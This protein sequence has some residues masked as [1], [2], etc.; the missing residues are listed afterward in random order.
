MVSYGCIRRRLGRP[1]LPSVSG[2]SLLYCCLSIGVLYKQLNEKP[3]GYTRLATLWNNRSQNTSRT[4]IHYGDEILQD[5]TDT[6]KGTF[7][8]LNVI[9]SVVILT[10]VGTTRIFLG[11]L[12][13]IE[14]AKLIDR[15]LRFLLLKVVFLGAVVNPEPA[16]V[17]GYLLWA[18]FTAFQKA[19]VGLAKD[20]GEALLSSP[21]ATIWQ[22]MRCASL[23]GL[24]LAENAA[25]II[26]G[27][28]LAGGT[29]QSQFSW[30]F[31]W[32]FDAAC[33][34]I[35][36][37]HASTRYLICGF[38]RWRAQRIQWDEDGTCNNHN[39]SYPA[40]AASAAS[41]ADTESRSQFLYLLDLASDLVVHALN[42]VHYG[43]ILHLRGGL[44]MQLIDV[45]L[46]TDVR[47]LIATVWRRGQGHIQYRKLTHKLRY[48]F[49][50]VPVEE[51]AKE[52]GVTCAICMENMRKSAKV[53]PCGHM[54]HLG[55]LREWLQQGQ[56][57]RSFTCPICRANLM[58]NEEGS[59][60]DEQES[61]DHTDHLNRVINERNYQHRHHY[62][63]A[64]VRRVPETSITGAAVR[65]RIYRGRQSGGIRRQMF[66]LPPAAAAELRENV[67]ATQ[68]RPTVAVY[69]PLA[70]D[71]YFIE[72]DE[73][74]VADGNHNDNFVQHHN[75]SI[76]NTSNHQTRNEIDSWGRE[77]EVDWDGASCRCH[78][79]DHENISGR[80]QGRHNCHQQINNNDHCHKNNG[81]DCNIAVGMLRR[82]WETDTNG[83]SSSTVAFHRG[84]RA[85][86]IDLQQTPEQEEDY[87]GDINRFP[88]NLHVSQRIASGSARRPVTR[89]MSRGL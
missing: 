63:R 16:D 44:R 43:H 87:N 19:F 33:I 54:Y 27:V 64:V 67:R 9:A 40:A 77:V 23:L 18:C 45:A 24:M 88:C 85:R 80:R 49:P 52:G 53:L 89:S 32:F 48:C 78:H 3:C 22:H 25:W 76:M 14:T 58:V 79:Q 35:E 81:N 12:N 21:T 6:R 62:H 82:G 34:G 15:M 29:A 11:Q 60:E 26:A 70:D 86:G 5:V 75:S 30:T 66:P 71:P 17:A 84:F 46:L 47:F 61:V 4:L 1:K 31:L 56:G 83:P 41:E 13:V 37:M 73:G 55:C 7:I 51:L 36:A 42:L 69:Y 20:R 50:D 74:D 72:N 39:P 68:N 65:R 57:M 28:R 38:D 2:L 10:A 59:D 8:A